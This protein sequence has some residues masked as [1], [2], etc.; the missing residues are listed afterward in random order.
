MSIHSQSSNSTAA[1]PS[2][3]QQFLWTVRREFWE[4]RSLYVAPFAMAVIALLGYLM[5][6]YGSFGKLR[7]IGEGSAAAQRI[8]LLIPFSAAT[9]AIMATASLTA[10]YYSLDALYGERRDRSVLFWKSLPIS[11]TTAVLAKIAVPM[12]AMIPIELAIIVATQFAM[13]V[14]SSISLTLS[15]DGANLLWQKFPF[16]KMAVGVVYGLVTGT[17]WYA[18]I[19]AWLLLASAWAKR[20]PVLWAT[21]PF[22]ALIVIERVAFGTLR[23]WNVMEN[24]VFGG[25]RAAFTNNAAPVSPT[26]RSEAATQILEQLGDISDVVVPDPAKFFSNPKLWIGLVLAA[27]FIVAAIRIRRYRGPI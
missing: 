6:I 20:A 19:Y 10:F 25:T 18:P 9:F 14:M 13:V 1:P 16:A 11:D 4:H 2:P 7:T 15:G 24:R 8:I 21:L 27:A 26:N 5:L 23:I 22:V 17:L 3:M 12:L